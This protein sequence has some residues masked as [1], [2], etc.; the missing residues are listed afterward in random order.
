MSV[1]CAPGARAGVFGDWFNGALI[2][3]DDGLLD[4]SDY[5]ASAQGFLPIPI[6]ITEPAVGFGLGLAV[7]YFH[8]PRELD[9][10]KHPHRGPPSISIGMGAKTENGTYFYGAG[11]LGVWKDDHIR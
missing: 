4:A 5:L 7:A 6:I 11:H 9:S 3:P 10:E 1:L 2:D 8:A